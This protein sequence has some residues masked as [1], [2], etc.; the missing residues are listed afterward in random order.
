MI[1]EYSYTHISS[2]FMIKKK[3]IHCTAIK[4][5]QTMKNYVAIKIIFFFYLNNLPYNSC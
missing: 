1:D 4:Q 3:T 5:I 2:E